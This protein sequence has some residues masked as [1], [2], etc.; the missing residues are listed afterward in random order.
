MRGDL[1]AS[2]LLDI[3]LLTVSAPWP[4]GRHYVLVDLAYCLLGPGPA[5][6]PSTAGCWASV[7]FSV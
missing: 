4:L 7:L 1:V 6:P 3:A 5:T 2:G